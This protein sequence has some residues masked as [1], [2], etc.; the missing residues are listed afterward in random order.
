MERIDLTDEQWLAVDEAL[1]ENNPLLAI[2]LIRQQFSRLGLHQ[3]GD[4]M[5]S[6]YKLLREQ[7]PQR[8]TLTDEEYWSEWYS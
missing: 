5:H 8:F 7:S 6:R 2:K 4:V 3:A 1:F